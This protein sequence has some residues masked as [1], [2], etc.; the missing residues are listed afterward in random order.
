ML[1][2]WVSIIQMEREIRE[3]IEQRHLAQSQIE[4]LM[5]MVGNGQKSRKVISIS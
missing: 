3:L 1:I 4:D 2:I 5:C